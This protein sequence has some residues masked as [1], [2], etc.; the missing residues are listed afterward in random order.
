[1]IE[2]H[3]KEAEHGVLGAMLQQPH[4]ID[5][6]SSEVAA[7]DFYYRENEALFRL[8]L[9]VHESGELVDI[10]TLSEKRQELC[11][12]FS[13]MQYAG[14]LQKNVP[15]TAN[16]KVY[17]GIV[18]ERAQA[19]QITAA[20]G[21][22]HEIA[23]Q[24]MPI[25]DKIAQ[26]QAEVLALN[27]KG[28]EVEC[29]V[30]GD[31]LQAHIDVLEA[32]H[33]KGGAL[34]GL[35][36]GIKDVDEQLQGMKPGQMIVLAARPAMGK[37]TFAMNIAEDVAIRQ[38]RP[39]FVA[40]LEMSNGQL[41]DRLLSAVGSIPLSA[42]KSGAAASDFGTHLMSAAAK[43][44]NAPLV[45]SDIPCMT[46]PRIRSIAR[47]LKHRMGDLGLIVID[48]LQLIE[49]EGQG[50]VEDVSAMSRQVKLMA[51]EMQCPVLVLSQLNRSCESRPDKRPVLSDLRESGAIEQDADIVMVIYRDE[52][53]YPDSQD[54]GVAEIILRKH[55]DGEI[56][57]V[58]T[59]FRGDI[60]RFAPLAGNHLRAVRVEAGF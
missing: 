55:R 1:M 38:K 30:V 35:S 15:G 58:K 37:T 42:I 45:V 4:L 60:S 41:M 40:S 56:G 46:L 27:G 10:I 32:R 21:R 3:S 23:H 14:T 59:A 12:G 36:T 33:E 26:A 31:L 44:K 24:A 20:S 47:R 49:G 48:Y 53:Y 57:T 19:R 39:V 51:R 29:L 34:D 50:R 22:I 13:T 25:E 8:I 18:R 52:V 28:S 16:A 17:A 6:L 11:P 5:V 43:L 7:S 9:A 2:L 54:K